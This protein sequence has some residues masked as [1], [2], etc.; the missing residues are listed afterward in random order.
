MKSL[1]MQLHSPK[2]KQLTKSK[3]L[4]YN[5]F[6]ELSHPLT[7]VIAYPQAKHAWMHEYMNVRIQELPEQHNHLCIARPYRA[8][9]VL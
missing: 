2:Y 3:G 4:K 5:F 6:I 1:K 7:W 9:F 8:Y